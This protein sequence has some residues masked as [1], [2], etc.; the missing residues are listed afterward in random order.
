MGV[1][2]IRIS[3]KTSLKAIALSEN[4][5]KRSLKT[6][7]LIRSI[8]VMSC[9]I[10]Q[11]ISNMSCTHRYFF[12]PPLDLVDSEEL[13]GN[14]PRTLNFLNGIRIVLDLVLSDQFKTVRIDPAGAVF[15]FDLPSG[16]VRRILRLIDHGHYI[17]GVH[18]FALSASGAGLIERS[19]V[20]ARKLVQRF[21]L[22]SPDRGDTAAILNF[23]SGS[24][25]Y[26]NHKNIIPNQ[27]GI[28]SE[29]VYG[30]SH[31]DEAVAISRFL[32][33]ALGGL[34]S[35]NQPHRRIIV[36]VL[37]RGKDIDVAQLDPP[38]SRCNLNLC[39]PA[40]K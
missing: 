33:L 2:Y 17:S 37:I 39:N 32:K 35:A 27:C 6:H 9:I 22:I 31:G 23:W 14:H 25:R 28:L 4:I 11:I 13:I 36:I 16:N 12:K 5:I 24:H 21:D 20:L 19:L 18:N 1:S 34:K 10:E 38:P 29:F 40:R 8:V 15:R 26:G 3:M 30:V 7:C